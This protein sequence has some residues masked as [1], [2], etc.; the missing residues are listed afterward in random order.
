MPHLV[1][2]QVTRDEPGQPEPPHDVALI[3]CTV[4]SECAQRTPQRRH[5]GDVALGVPR[6]QTV[7]EKVDVS[8]RL[9]CRWGTSGG[10]RQLTRADAV[11]ETSGEDRSADRLQVGLARRAA[12]QRSEPIR[13]MEQ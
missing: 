11:T 4:L 6:H 2:P 3:A 13:G 7:E 1:V 9:P 12:V 5:T 10:C 8:W